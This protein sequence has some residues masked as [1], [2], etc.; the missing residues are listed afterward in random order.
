MA[1]VVGQIGQEGEGQVWGCDGHLGL[2]HSQSPVT[3]RCQ[4]IV[5]GVIIVWLGRL[6]PGTRA[7][8]ASQTLQNISL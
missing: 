4:G 8:T 3:E 1:A 6:P 7:L 5:H 2:C